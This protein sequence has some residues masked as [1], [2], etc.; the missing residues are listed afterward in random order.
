MDVARRL[1]Q[2]VND[3]IRFAVETSRT[4]RFSLSGTS[5]SLAIECAR[6]RGLPCT[7]PHAV[8]NDVFVMHTR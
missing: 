3:T 4:V 8:T 5:L 6:V 7:W 1:C 2:I